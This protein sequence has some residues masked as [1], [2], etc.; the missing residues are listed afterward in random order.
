MTPNI[1][2]MIAGIVGL[3]ILYVNIWSR[4]QKVSL[5]KIEDE[6]KISSTADVEDHLSLDHHTNTVSQDLSAHVYLS[7]VWVWAPLLISIWACYDPHFV[8]GIW[9][10]GIESSQWLSF[11]LRYEELTQGTAV[12]QSPLYWGS[13]SI[14]LWAYVLLSLS[15]LSFFARW[16]RFARTAQITLALWSMTIIA[17][18]STLPLS[19]TKVMQGEA[20]IRSYLEYSPLQMQRVLAFVPPS[21]S[22]TFTTKIP[23]FML[24]ALS[25]SILGWILPQRVLPRLKSIQAFENRGRPL[26]G[27]IALVPILAAVWSL[28][29][30]GSFYGSTQQY[31]LWIS[32]LLMSVAV[33]FTHHAV[34]ALWVCMTAVILLS[35][36]PII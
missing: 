14:H 34:H 7:M 10:Q 18:W 35:I 33:I 30:Q 27:I 2:A 25:C 6:D 3:L 32:A 13:T 16:V 20:G 28:L 15:V 36:H 31:I 1:L 21:E 22:W 23:Y 5:T 24:L 29:I 11:T 12:F 9:G 8:L 4:S 26:L 17:W 19:L